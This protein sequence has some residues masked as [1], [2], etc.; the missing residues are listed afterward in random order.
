MLLLLC[1]IHAV[2]LNSSP[3]IKST[4]GEREFE[5]AMSADAF[6]FVKF[7]HPRCPHCQAM[8]K[9]FVELSFKVSE[10]NRASATPQNHTIKAIEVDASKK[11]NRPVLEA[12]APAFPTLKL[13]RSGK[14][15]TEFFGPRQVTPMYEFLM[16]SLEV[17][18]RPLVTHLGTPKQVEDFLAVGSDRPVIISLFQ[19]RVG[20]AIEKDTIARNHFPSHIQLSATE[21][22]ETIEI[23]HEHTAPQAIF[24][25]VPHPSLLVTD[26]LQE[27]FDGIKSRH[28]VPPLLAAAPRA[29]SFNTSA[30]WYFPGVRDGAPASSFMHTAIIGDEQF[31]TLGEHNSPHILETTRPLAIAFGRKDSPGY[32]E[33]EFLL[34][35]AEQ[36][37]SPKILPVYASM[38]H[39]LDFAEHVGLNVSDFH[40]NEGSLEKWETKYVM[41]RFGNRGPVTEFYS[42][43]DETS[44]GSWLR[45]Q[46]RNVNETDVATTAGEVLELDTSSW[47]NLFEFDGRGVIL[48]LYDSE[49]SSCNLQSTSTRVA[50]QLRE[51]AGSII[52]ARFD[53]GS[54]ELPK[55]PVLANDTSAPEMVWVAPGETPTAYDGF[56][57]SR[58]VAR[59]ALEISGLKGEDVDWI[60]VLLSYMVVVGVCMTVAGIWIMYRARRQKWKRDHVT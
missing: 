27:R 4:L 32:Y 29:S 24:A 14:L 8:A 44:T 37:S 51:F 6:S 13:F 47:E 34:D 39:S 28:F 17:A 31:V 22:D 11:E 50:A 43:K 26:S 54:Y 53:I 40:T 59:F 35:A 48:E 30:E 33:E 25:T 45:Q 19:P 52:V 49:C 7:F 36:Q 57:S 10:H 2:P 42:E 18:D 16:R 56:R 9:D 55:W 15:I 5:E 58:G 21:W 3:P 23:M 46:A 1:A 12:H 60:D 38:K 20:S 41:Y